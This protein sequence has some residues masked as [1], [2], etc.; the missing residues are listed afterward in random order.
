MTSSKFNQVKLGDVIISANTGL[1]AIKRAPIVNYNTGIKCLRIQDISQNKQFDSWGFCEVEENNFNRFSLKKGDILIART[2]ATI[3]VNIQIKDNL[4]AVYNNGLIRLKIN[5]EIANNKFVFYNLQT[6]YYKNFIN[7]I[8]AGTSTQPNMQI[9]SLL[10]FEIPLP[11]LETQEKIARVLSSLDDKIEL[12][13]KINQNLEQQAQAIFDKFFGSCQIENKIIGDYLTPKRGK[14]LLSKDTKDGNIPVIA[15]GLKPAAYHNIAN[16]T[17]PVITISASGANAGYVNLWQIPVWASD[18]SYIDSTINP[19][20]YFWYILLKKRQKEIFD[21]QT[22]SAQPHIYP[23]HIEQMA[24]FDLNIINVKNYNDMIQ[25]LFETIGN[26]LSENKQLT[27]LR[28]TLL[29]KL[30]SG[31]IDIDKV[32]I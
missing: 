18:S 21:S 32:E 23:K 28:D 14:N 5:N 16:T 10:S 30:M 1:D 8:S 19:Y 31:E 13:N 25:P 3:G 24:I 9:N 6:Q 4:I 29:P 2:G 12:N 17:A 15:G 22:G 7:A 26:N 11:P 27:Q 20:I